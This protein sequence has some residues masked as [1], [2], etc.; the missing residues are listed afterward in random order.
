MRRHRFEPLGGGRLTGLAGRTGAAVDV[1]SMAW[2]EA[3]APFFGKLWSRP[4]SG[5]G[6]VTHPVFPVLHPPH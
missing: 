3:T 5:A 4:A 6:G 1:V 2:E